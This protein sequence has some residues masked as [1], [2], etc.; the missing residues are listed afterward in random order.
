PFHAGR[1]D[2]HAPH[3]ESARTRLF[4]KEAPKSGSWDMP[5]DDV[6]CDLGSVTGGEVI[7]NA[8]LFLDGLD[9]SRLDDLRMETGSLQVLN[10]AGTATTARVSMD[11][12]LLLCR[13]RATYRKDGSTAQK[14]K[15][16][17]PSQHC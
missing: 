2:R 14:N 17:A 13:T 10:P 8:K 6:T 15:G 9:I 3:S 16:G 7:W 5:F 1:P 11:R 4:R 12:D